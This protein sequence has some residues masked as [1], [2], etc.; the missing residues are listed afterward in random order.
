MPRAQEYYWQLGWQ[1]GERE[2]VAD[3]AAGARGRFDS[4]DPEDAARWLDAQ[5]TADAG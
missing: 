2:A 4:D 1:Q 3:L 5:D